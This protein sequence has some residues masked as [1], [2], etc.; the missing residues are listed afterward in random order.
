MTG[1]Q[2]LILASGSPH[3]RELLAQIGVAP[4]EIV[5]PD[6]DETPRQGEL[7]RELALRLAKEKAAAAREHMKQDP[8]STF[9]LAADTVVAVGRR[10]LGRASSAEEAERYLSLLSGRGHRVFTALALIAHAT[11]PR[12]R[13]VESRLRFK[14]LSKAELE[15]YVRS[16]EWRGKAGAYAIQ[17]FAG[18]FVIRLVG[19]YSN[20]VGL[21]LAETAA[22]LEGAGY[23]IRQSG[24]R[25]VMT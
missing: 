18:A 20:V 15:A 6:V 19:S 16:E 13:I 21:P 1:R 12:A 9:V 10:P 14:R 7:P 24:A 2:R 3:R 11:K 8:A 25:E 17:G 5:V 4:D 23:P 22:L